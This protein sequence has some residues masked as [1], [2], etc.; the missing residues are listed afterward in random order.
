MIKLKIKNIMWLTAFLLLAFPGC[1]IGSLR[2][3]VLTTILTF[4][5][6]FI[7]TPRELIFSLCLCTKRRTSK[8]LL[9]LFGWIIFSGMFSILLGCCSLITLL[10]NILFRF[11]PL[12]LIPYFLGFYIAKNFTIN[13]IIKFYYIL[14]LFIFFIGFLDF[15]LSL[16]HCP[17]LTYTIVNQRGAGAY[18]GR[19]RSVFL[20]PSYMNWFLAVHLP[21]MYEMSKSR[22][23]FFKNKYINYISKVLSIFA[24]IMVFLSKS[25][26]FIFIFFIETYVYML[27]SSK[28]KKKMLLNTCIC[29]ILIVSS[30]SIMNSSI[31]INTFLGRILNVCHNLSNLDALISG[32][33]SLANRIISYIAAFKVFLKNPFVGV[34]FGNSGIHVNALFQ[35]GVLPLTYEIQMALLDGKLGCNYAILWTTLAENGLFGVI[36]LYSILIRTLK[37]T[38]LI[39]KKM[40]FKYKL[41]FSGLFY[42]FITIILLSIY[43]SGITLSYIWFSVGIIS[44]Y[45]KIRKEKING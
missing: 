29:I 24:W 35:A 40:Y 38:Y 17:I 28:N 30:I 41:F 18:M 34:G 39:L 8:L 11:I 4:I 26:M 31:I 21:L 15:I 42:S 23:T 1:Y 27:F 22:F 44:L 19:V 45:S 3:T 20:E 16:F 9:Y 32:D 43:D 37:D 10:S 25:P 33:N 2:L 14:F 7:F 36:L 6:L 13:K 12:V 5:I